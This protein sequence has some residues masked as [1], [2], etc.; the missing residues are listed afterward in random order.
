ML[1]IQNKKPIETKEIDNGNKTIIIH[2]AWHFLGFNPNEHEKKLLFYILLCVIE[3]PI[4]F[5]H[6]YSKFFAC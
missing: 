6:N 4:S 1:R 2:K 5:Y 3:I